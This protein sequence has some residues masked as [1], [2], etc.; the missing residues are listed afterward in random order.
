VPV[1]PAELN[2]MTWADGVATAT[3]DAPA[4]VFALPQQRHVAAVRLK[5]AYENTASPA[6]CTFC[7]KGKG[8]TD[9]NESERSLFWPQDTTPGEKTKL[10]GVDDTIDQFR[11]APDNKAC[12][13]RIMEITLLL[14]PNAAE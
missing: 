10:I 8:Q 7:W 1:I 11:L 5:L 2:Q 12:M 4:L 14:S 9:A 6:A 3:G 13:V